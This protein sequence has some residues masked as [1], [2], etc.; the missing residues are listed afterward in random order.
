VFFFPQMACFFDKGER[1]WRKS[2]QGSQLL[3]VSC[4]D[5]KSKELQ[6]EQCDFYPPVYS[7]R[8]NLLTDWCVNI[9]TEIWAKLN[10]RL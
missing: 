3:I 1:Y 2:M 4:Q 10:R 5:L 6:H 9:V 8:R 7:L